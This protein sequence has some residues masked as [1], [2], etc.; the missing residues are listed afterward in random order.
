[1]LG[2]TVSHY[3]ILGQLGA[4]GMGVVYEAEDLKLGRHVA[5]KFLPERLAGEPQALERFQ[6]EARAASALNHPSICTIHDID[7]SGGQWFLVM[8]LLQGETLAKKIA[9]HPL[10]LEAVLDLGTQIAD[11]LDAAHAHGIVHRDIKPANIFV[12]TR[13]QAKIL[14]FG[15][16]KLQSAAAMEVAAMPTA[17]TPEHLTSPG[18]TV[19]TVAYMSPEQIRGQELDAR[20]D[21]FS[22]GAVLYEMATGGLPFP[23]ATSGLIFEAILNRTPA[24][25][26]RLNPTLPPRLEEII[27]KALEKD[28]EVRYQSAAE[29][30]ADLRRLKRDTESGRMTAAAEPSRRQKRPGVRG[31]V[32]V[33]GILALGLV[34]FLGEY[35]VRSRVIRAKAPA[36]PPAA[37]VTAPAAHTLAVLPFHNLSAEGKDNSWGIG[38]TDAVISRLASLHDLAVRPTSSVLKYAQATADPVKAAQ[39]LRVDSVLDGT[40]QSAAGS[41]RVSVQLI[42]AKDGATRWAQRYDLRA[43][44][45]FKFEDE[46]ASRVVEGMQV[47]VSSVE[48]NS[49]QKPVTASPDAYNDYL[50]ARFYRNEYFMHSRRESLREGRRLLQQALAVDP[51]FTDAQA[52]LS[53]MYLMEAANFEENGAA[54]VRLAADAAERALRQN[55]RSLAAL[56]SMGDIYAETGQNA[57][58]IRTLRQTVALAPNSET[59]WDFLGYAYHYAGLVEQAEQAYRRSRQLNPTTPRIYWMHGRMLL[60]LGKPDEAEKV[61]RQALAANPDQFKATA[62]LG[63]FL[64]YQ[65]KTAEAEPILERAVQLGKGNGDAVPLWLS[66]FLYA[67]RGERQKIDPSLFEYKPQEVIDGDVAYWAGSMYALLG[68][69]DKAIVWLRRAVELGNQ[70]YPWFQRDKNW[71][72]LRNDAEYQQ[73]MAQVRR[74]WE[75]Y[76]EEFGQS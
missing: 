5:L 53:D 27:S 24:A 15:L 3:R 42:D 50:Q 31:A 1:M 75:Q 2:Q 58:A 11:G 63:E 19:G 21:L 61:M 23:G 6:R 36:K 32:V 69:R 62:F 26:V 46:L 8:E 17:A 70:N 28:R 20:T 44:D 18:T 43:G 33:A 45:M 30:R 29:M 71:D 7:E 34:V 47:Q 65:G 35:Y 14:D 57:Q 66:A 40:Y 10:E 22:F 72:K 52:M 13:G 73:I 64:Y 41:V 55:P 16:A 49:L 59:S 68:E 37:E 60:Y 51:N 76:T 12:T 9:G 67:S 56:Q 74:Q 48:Q 25:P 54:N 4:G 38:M 39:E